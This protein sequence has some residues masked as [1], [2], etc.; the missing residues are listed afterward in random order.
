M[1]SFMTAFLGRPAPSQNN[2]LVTPRAKRFLYAKTGSLCFAIA[3]DSVTQAIE[4][5][6]I[7]PHDM[8]P[9]RFVGMIWPIRFRFS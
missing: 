7:Q 4:Q 5:P 2:Q 9:E 6:V 3:S 8:L 1:A